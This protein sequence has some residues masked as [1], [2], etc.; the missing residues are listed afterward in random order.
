M[1]N[2]PLDTSFITYRNAV[3]RELCNEVY[4]SPAI[5][6]NDLGKILSHSEI[7]VLV[8]L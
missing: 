4:V 1:D 5:V 6:A 8:T 7:L 3:S 2:M